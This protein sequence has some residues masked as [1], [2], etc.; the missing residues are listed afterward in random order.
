MGHGFPHFRLIL[1]SVT[2]RQK[3]WA[4]IAS[5]LESATRMRY[6]QRV[7]LDFQLS[8]PGIA[9]KHPGPFF[10]ILPFQVRR[11]RNFVRTAADFCPLGVRHSLFARD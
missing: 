10:L 5:I 4:P 9:A 11:K 6:I 1:G 8:G 7:V 2:S 3:Q